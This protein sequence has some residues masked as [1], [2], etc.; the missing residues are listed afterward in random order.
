MTPK[1]NSTDTSTAGALESPAR[2]SRVTRERTNDSITAR[3]IGMR[4]PCAT[5]NAVTTTA[6]TARLSRLLISGV[7]AG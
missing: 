1:V 6:A 4:T 2:P 7:P 3:M 5:N